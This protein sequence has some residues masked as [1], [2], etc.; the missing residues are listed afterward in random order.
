L[1]AG[2]AAWLALGTALPVGAVELTATTDET[3]YATLDYYGGLM[4]SSVV[5][6]VRTFGNATLTDY[7]SYDEVTNLTD[8]R[9]AVVSGDKVSFDLTGNVPD[10]FYFEAKTAQPYTDFPWTLSLS[11]TLNGLP[12]KAEELAGQQGVVEI[13]LDAVPNLAASEYSR[14]N[15]VLTAMSM[16]NGDEILSLEAPGA[17]V[18]LVGNLYCVLYMVMPGEEQHFTI[19][20][21]SDDFSYAGMIS[22]PSPQPWTSCPKS[23]T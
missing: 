12:A 2:L 20:V 15:L 17:Q 5:K 14:N 16:F 10:K 22:W 6:S 21:G 4:D 18:Q 3:Y 9:E 7:G 19:R 1:T 8:D 13:N 23:R 11:Y